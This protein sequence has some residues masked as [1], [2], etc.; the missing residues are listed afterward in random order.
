MSKRRN[1]DY[2]TLCVYVRRNNHRLLKVLAALQGRTMSEITEELIEGW[3][4]GKTEV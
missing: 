1:P 4:S 3:L 2:S